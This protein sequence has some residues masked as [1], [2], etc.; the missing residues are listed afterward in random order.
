MR[1]EAFPRMAG[2]MKP[3]AD[4]GPAAPDRDAFS[5]V[6]QPLVVFGFPRAVLSMR[7]S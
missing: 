1:L 3:S 6:Q 5:I 4:A 2:G 7:Q